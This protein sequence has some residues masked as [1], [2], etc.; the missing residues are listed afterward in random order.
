MKSSKENEK[1]VKFLGDMPGDQ[2]RKF[3]Y[4]LIDWIA[5]YLEHIEDYPVLSHVKPGNIKKQLPLSPPGSGEDMEKILKDVDKIILPG[6]THWNHPHFMAYFNSTSGGPGILAELL[7][8]AFNSNGMLWRTNPSSSELEQ[9]TLQWLRQMLGMPEDFWGII[10]DTASVASMHAIAAAREQAGI[11][12]R[13]KGLAGRNDLPKLRLY[14]SEQAHSSI[15]KSAITL[16]IGLES[17]R[18]IP[19]DNEFRMLPIELDKAIKEDKKNGWLPFCVVATVGTTSTTS[20]DPVNDIAE[21]CGKENLWL[22]V[23]GA[24]GGSAAIIP[25]MQ[26]IFKG[27][28]RADSFLINPHKWLFNPVDITAFYT[29]KPEVLKRA[30]S[31]VADYLKTPEENV[32][33]NYMDYGIQLGR[34]F[35]AL[36]LWF[37]IRYFGVEGLRER[38]RY[39][40]YLGWEF[41][42]WVDEHPDFER[43]APVPLSTICFRLHPENIND[44]NKL[45]E[46]NLS[47]FKEIDTNSDIMISHTR[48]NDKYV[49]RVNMSGL[50]MELRH[51]EKAWEIIKIKAGDILAKL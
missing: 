2:F 40:L 5:N 45:E 1:E 8:A 29:R 15:D 4:E 35:R 23:D 6:V 44:E 43:M 41:T 7:S 28:E 19:T 26:W 38:L 47:F 13:E 11:N 42:K 50:R 48:L 21:I 9:H 30:F 12:V 46:L 31:L 17:L 24:H 37:T 25:E 10:Y 14:A 33:D 22:H 39:H 49:L 36:K 20:I 3:G 51:I 18:K 16:G 34:R 32:V 27:V